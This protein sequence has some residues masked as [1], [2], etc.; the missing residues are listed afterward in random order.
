[1]TPV[2]ALLAAFHL[3]KLAGLV[4]NLRAFPTLPETGAYP[5]GLPRTSLLVPARD[6]A[7]RLPLA[8]PG[9]LAQPVAEV[10]VLDDQ[11]RDATARVVV[12]AARK[13]PRLRLVPGSRP[14]AGWVGKSWAC[15]QLATA[16]TGELLIFC[17]AD[18]TL[19]P[20]AVAAAW[21]ELVRQGCDVLS[22]FPRQR[23]GTVGE[24]LLVPLIDEVLLA[25]LPH[26]LLSLPL[27]AAAT[28]NGQFLAFRREAYRRMG[29]HRAVAGKL[30]E[31][32]A[33][34]RAVRRGG[35][36]LGLSLGGSMVTARMYRGYRET[37]RG[38]GKSMRAAHGGSD[39]A[40]LASAAFHLAA[41]TLPWLRWRHGGWWRLAALAGPL[42]RLLTNAA[43]G[44][45]AYAEALLVPVTAPA[46]LPV[47]A[48]AA[49]RTAVWKGRRYR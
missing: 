2:A 18:V 14:P 44:R 9:L 36:R 24:R 17:D 32:V 29:G 1:V 6:E 33:L 12:N 45:R 38:L 20:G 15:Q 10:L 31:D 22:V 48:V 49:R 37:V 34:A 41:Y 4:A 47:Y 30:V 25:F 23:T 21:G 19:R 46:A 7:A 11:S 13:D 5:A 35:L 27:P 40:L 3:L 26:R 39:A 42:E 28:A 43:T 16:A 8:L